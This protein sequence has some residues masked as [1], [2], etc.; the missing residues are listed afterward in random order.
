MSVPL[1]GGAGLDNLEGDQ[2]KTV[3]LQNISNIICIITSKKCV[4]V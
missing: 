2:I 4:S 3:S 1:P